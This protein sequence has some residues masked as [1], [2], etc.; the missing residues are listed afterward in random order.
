MIGAATLVRDW[1]GHSRDGGTYAATCG[2]RSVDSC[3]GVRTRPTPAGDDT[4]FSQLSVLH[5]MVKRDADPSF[6][7]PCSETI[8]IPATVANHYVPREEQELS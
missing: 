3:H 5:D 4:L 7:P 6:R 2:Q 1:T 8:N